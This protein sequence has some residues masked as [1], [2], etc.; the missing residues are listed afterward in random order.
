ML[1]EI[2]TIVSTGPNSP[3]SEDLA[4]EAIG[5]N[6]GRYLSLQGG[7]GHSLGRAA[8]DEHFKNAPQFD[9]EIIAQHRGRCVLWSIFQNKQHHPSR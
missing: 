8:L 4:G 1:A 6:C 2:N 7:S 5:D 3:I 9:F